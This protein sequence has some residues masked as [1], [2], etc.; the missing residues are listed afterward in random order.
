[1]FYQKGILKKIQKKTSLFFNKVAGPRPRRCFSLN[2]VKACNS[3][4]KQTLAQLFSSEFCEFFKNTIFDITPLT[5][6]SQRSYVWSF[7][8]KFVTDVFLNFFRNSYT[9]EHLCWKSDESNLKF[10]VK[11][12][13]IKIEL[14]F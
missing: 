13:L 10:W 4:K 7:T 11:K 12:N 14:L 6:A 8:E 1:M 9:T 2:F 5:V 3:I